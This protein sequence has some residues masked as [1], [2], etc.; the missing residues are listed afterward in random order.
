MNTSQEYIALWIDSSNQESFS[1]WM[2]KALIFGSN[3]V[4]MVFW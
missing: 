4:G 2:M 3:S 1:E